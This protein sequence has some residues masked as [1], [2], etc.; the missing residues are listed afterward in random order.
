[1]SDKHNLR[2]TFVP[3]SNLDYEQER[4]KQEISEQEI[5][6]QERAEYER[7]NRARGIPQY[8]L[9]EQNRKPLYNSPYQSP[10]IVFS[11]IAIIIGLVYTYKDKN[12][13]IFIILSILLV[14]V[15]IFAKMIDYI[16]AMLLM[17]FIG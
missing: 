6:E 3:S 7:R 8:V 16:F 11:I 10:V 15:V 4:A 2:A 5:S 1:M 14:V 12:N 17:N 9:D 13:T